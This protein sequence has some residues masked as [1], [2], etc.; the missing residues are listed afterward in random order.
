MNIRAV[1]PQYNAIGQPG[2]DKCMICRKGG[3][4]DQFQTVMAGYSNKEKLGS[5]NCPW[6]R[7]VHTNHINEQWR[8]S[9]VLYLL[10]RAV[11]WDVEK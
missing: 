10:Q 8:G 3:I 11:Y 7:L 9:Q 2:M 6:D 4:K 1:T 5:D